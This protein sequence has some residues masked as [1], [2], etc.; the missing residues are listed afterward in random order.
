MSVER[1]TGVRRTVRQFALALVACLAVAGGAVAA[2]G[3]QGDAP[4]QQL[5]V[6]DD[7]WPIQTPAPGN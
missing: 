1:N 3:G 2:V 6:A 7:N 5:V 4:V